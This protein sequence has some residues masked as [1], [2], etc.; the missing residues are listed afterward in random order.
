[1]PRP[2]L[3]DPDE[4]IEKAMHSFWR[5]GYEGT[6]VRM[7]EK[8]MGINQFSMYASFGN[9]ER[10]F[11]EVLRKYRHVATKTFFNKLMVSEGRIKD[12]KEFLED[13]A[14]S[15]ESGRTP[16]GCLAINTSMEMGNSNQGITTE[17]KLYFDFVKNLFRKTLGKAKRNGEVRKDL[18][19]DKGAVYLLGCTQGVSVMSKVYPKKEVMKFIDLSL[20]T[21]L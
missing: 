2:K 9:K 3:Y 12:I 1:M 5:N 4:V 6:S 15:I 10:L 11:L 21:L 14:G 19:T 13:F 20:Q 16:N 8:D 17:L 18:D 7:L